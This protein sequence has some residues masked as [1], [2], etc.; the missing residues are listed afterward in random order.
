M[1]LMLTFKVIYD[2]KDTE[3]HVGSELDAGLPGTQG[4]E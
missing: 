4:V 1:T 2:F 3:I